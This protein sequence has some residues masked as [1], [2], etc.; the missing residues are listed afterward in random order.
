MY[1]TYTLLLG[2]VLLS[3][4]ILLNGCEETTSGG[5]GS[6]DLGR[7]E[8]KIVESVMSI[9]V[10]DDRPDGITDTFSSE[11]DEQ[12]YLWILWGNIDETHKVKIEWYSPE[13]DVDDP[14]FW[15]DEST[16]SSTTGEKITWFYI[17]APE[18][19]LSGDQ[20]SA[21]WWSVDIFLDGLFERSHL[22][23]ME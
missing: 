13:E 7:G 17:D 18:G 14:P 3:L 15:S 16:I 9:S 8:P 5:S 11:A 2:A 23:Y 6:I 4:A 1:R 20:F 12:V 19:G 10:H 21:G 22:F